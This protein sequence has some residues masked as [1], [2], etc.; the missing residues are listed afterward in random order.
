MRTQPPAHL[1]SPA[2]RVRSSALGS[3]GMG[4]SLSSY[5][6]SSLYFDKAIRP[7]ICEASAKGKVNIKC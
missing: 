5:P 1:G 4:F 3:S 6:P 2:A 7:T